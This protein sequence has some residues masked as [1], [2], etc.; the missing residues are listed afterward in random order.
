[1]ASAD[2]PLLTA[3]ARG[4]AFLDSIIHRCS[5]LQN[6][7]DEDLDFNTASLQDADGLLDGCVTIKEANNL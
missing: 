4:R 3:R 7:S 5:E 6:W 1:M 2:E